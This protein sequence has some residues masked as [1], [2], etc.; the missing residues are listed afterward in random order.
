MAASMSVR[1]YMVAGAEFRDPGDAG[2][3]PS[4]GPFFCRPIPYI[5]CRIAQSLQLD[6]SEMASV[7]DRRVFPV[8]T[9]VRLNQAGRSV[10]RAPEREG[11]VTGLGWRFARTRIVRWDGRKSTEAVSISY[12]EQVD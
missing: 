4:A 11:T 7:Q 10:V 3:R 6:Q 5:L 2:G 12:L 8:G 1:V 9:R